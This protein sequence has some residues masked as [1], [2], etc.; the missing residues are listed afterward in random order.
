MNYRNIALAASSVFLFG[1]VVY[2]AWPTAPSWVRSWVGPSAACDEPEFDFGSVPSGPPI[3]HVFSIRNGGRRALEIVKVGPDCGCITVS[4]PEKVVPPGGSVPI[5]VS[6]ASA[7]LRGAQRH[8]IL[9]VT[10]DPARRHLILRL[11]GVVVA[12][13]ETVPAVGK[14]T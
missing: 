12:G 7:G 2:A 5:E 14:G 4:S 11:Q 9:V 8:N 6:V 10:N 1:C 3:R 13:Q